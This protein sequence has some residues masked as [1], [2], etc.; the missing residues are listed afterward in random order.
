MDLNSF[1]HVIES[2]NSALVNG[3]LGNLDQSW[4]CSFS[5]CLKFG[6]NMRSF[7]VLWDHISCY[8]RR[9]RSECKS[10]RGLDE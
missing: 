4:S 2:H 9:S 10:G 3:V 6:T 1:L 5:V 7:S 8:L